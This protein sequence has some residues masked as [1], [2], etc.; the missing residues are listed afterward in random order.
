MLSAGLWSQL[1]NDFSKLVFMYHVKIFYGQSGK[2]LSSAH[3][4]IKMSGKSNSPSEVAVV[5]SKVAEGGQEVK[6][7]DKVTRED[8]EMKG[9][10]NKL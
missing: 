8:T 7:A 9:N 4:Q 10:G 3:L 1:L 6:E 5:D 2:S